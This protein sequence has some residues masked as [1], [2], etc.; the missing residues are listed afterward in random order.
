MIAQEP[1]YIEEHI[2]QGKE[3]EVRVWRKKDNGYN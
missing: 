2:R 1:F 3:P